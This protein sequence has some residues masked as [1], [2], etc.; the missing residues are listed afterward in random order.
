MTSWDE[1][2]RFM[3][4]RLAGKDHSKATL[5]RTGL[6]SSAFGRARRWS[7]RQAVAIPRR[8]LDDSLEEEDEDVGENEQKE[9]S[10]LKEKEKE[11]PGM[12]SN[13]KEMTTHLAVRGWALSSLKLVNVYYL[14]EE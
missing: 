4:E 1:P 3:G 14:M 7:L 12:T 10:S 5:G 2:V 6:G 13:K 11:E 8:L 9:D